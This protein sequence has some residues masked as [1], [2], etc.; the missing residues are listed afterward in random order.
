M[1][2]DNNNKYRLQV[3]A[4]PEYDPACHT[5]VPVNQQE[6]VTFENDRAFVSLCVKV[7]NYRGYPEGSPSTNDYFSYPLHKNQKYSIAF[8]FQPKKA[9]SGDSLIFGNDFDNPIRDRLPPGLNTALRIVRWIIDPGVY[10]DAYADRPYLY[11]PALSSLNCLRICGKPG[12]YQIGSKNWRKELHNELI[13]EGGEAEGEVS[14]REMNI[15]DQAIQR[16]KHFLVRENRQDFWFEPGIVY[17]ADFGNGYIDFESFTI[18][19]IQYVNDKTHKLRYV[20]KDRDTGEV[21]FALVFN[22]IFEG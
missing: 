3:T 21:I 12:Y 13:D 11:G 10:G 16:R 4:G 22:L 2:R 17:K 9:I 18:P 19:V 5:I 1:T 6:T 15:P 20:L 8:S 7:Q 14:R